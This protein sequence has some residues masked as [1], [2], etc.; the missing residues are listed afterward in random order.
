VLHLPSNTTKQ[1]P[2]ELNITLNETNSTIALN[3]LLKKVKSGSKLF[4]EEIV[5]TLNDGTSLKIDP[6]SLLVE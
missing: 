2:E 4:F 3:Q 5:V 6:L 1:D